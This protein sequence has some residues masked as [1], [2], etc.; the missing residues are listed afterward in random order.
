MSELQER[1]SGWSL[2]RI[3][4]LTT[5][6]NKYNP[7]R[8]GSYIPLPKEIQD[9]KAFVNVKN[10]DKKCFMWSVL[11]GLYSKPIHPELISH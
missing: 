5:N 9:K 10:K 4:Y 3:L 2:K 11:A 8:V 7:M 1:S 6:I